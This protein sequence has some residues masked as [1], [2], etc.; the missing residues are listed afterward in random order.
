VNHPSGRPSFA[1]LKATLTIEQVLARRGL[2]RDLRR[3][4]D[5]L[6]GPCPIHH[7]D[8]PS[9]FV[10]STSKNLW[11]CFTRCGGGD[12]IELV[13]R[14]DN[15]SYADVGRHLAALAHAAEPSAHTPEQRQAPA[16]HRNFSPFTRSLPLD[17]HSPWL[18]AKGICPQTA[19]IFEAGRYHGHGFLRDCIAV[20]IHDPDGHPLGYAGRRL[21]P[22]EARIRGKWKLPP[23]FPAS[24]VLYGFHHTLPALSRGLVVV[25]CP[26]G[27]MR[28]AQL[29]VP[30]VALLGIRASDE[31]RRLLA[32]AP[33]L[34]LMLDGDAAGREG[35][36]RLQAALPAHDVSVVHLPDGHDPD[37][38]TDIELAALLP[39]FL[40]GQEGTSHHE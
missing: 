10:L 36:L 14:L 21:D 32:R 18:R 9:A 1:Q 37:D 22:E 28:L 16:P 25:E 38:L 17:H 4:G 15:C 7:G 19:Q 11:H 3:Q 6:V 39:P 34:V 33:R 27:V 2:L 24:R 35:A 12:L 26:W 13:R 40:P 23:A 5:R 29:A 31:Q 8:S 30:A 20:R